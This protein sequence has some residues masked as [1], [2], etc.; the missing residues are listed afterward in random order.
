[1]LDFTDILLINSGPASL[2]HHS[3]LPPNCLPLPLLNRTDE[4][5]KSRKRPWVDIR[6]GR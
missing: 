6:T 5:K 3:N 2:V 4:K 1:M